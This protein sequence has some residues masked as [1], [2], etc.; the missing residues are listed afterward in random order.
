M[1]E[2][3]RTSRLITGGVVIPSCYHKRQVC[4]AERRIQARDDI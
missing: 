2:L 3:V 1:F 4:A